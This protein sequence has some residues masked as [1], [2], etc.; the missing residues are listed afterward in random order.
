MDRAGAVGDFPVNEMTEVSVGDKQVLVI[1]DGGQFYATAAR[2]PHMRGHL[3]QG[4]LDGTI[5]TCP[6]HGSQFDAKTGKVVRW[7]NFTGFALAAAKALRHPRD[8]KT[9]Q[10]SIQDGDLFIEDA[11][12]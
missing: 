1:N 8:L 5:I 6:L 3:A 10:T 7:T 4:S 12:G 11:D 9:Y 2:C